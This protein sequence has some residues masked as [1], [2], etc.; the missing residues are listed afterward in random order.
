MPEPA[1]SS[2]VIKDETHVTQEPPR[3]RS[4]VFERPYD[5]LV[6]LDGRPVTAVVRPFFK[7][8]VRFKSHPSLSLSLHTSS[9]ST[10]FHRGKWER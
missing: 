10:P 3:R 9:R 1:I 4:L 5:R 7:P 6:G 8:F 2:D